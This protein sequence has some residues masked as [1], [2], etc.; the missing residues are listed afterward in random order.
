MH[1]EACSLT[2][3]PGF[4]VEIVRADDAARVECSHHMALKARKEAEA[5]VEAKKAK[6]YTN[7][8]GKSLT[9]SPGG[10]HSKSSP[11]KIHR[12]RPLSAQ[13]RKDQAADIFKQLVGEG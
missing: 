6:L 11:I 1:L 9:K 2:G 13:E 8:K 7:R 10:S 3:L 12:R 4:L 5:I